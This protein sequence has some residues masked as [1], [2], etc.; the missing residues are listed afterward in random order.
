M[1]RPALHAVFLCLM[2]PACS[3]TEMQG[4]DPREYYSRHP[5]KN[6]VE[7]KTEAHL[8]TFEPGAVKLTKGEIENFRHKVN[9]RSM[10]A[11]DSVM[12]DMSKAMLNN[13]SR[14]QSL[15]RMMKY[16]GYN[17]GNVRFQA[18]EGL[19][20]QQAVIHIT[21]AEAVLPDCPD[22]R[23]ASN[24]NYSNTS[25]ANFGCANE[26]NLGL[27]VADPRDLQRGTGELPPAVSERGD[28]VLHDY[29]GGKSYNGQEGS[30]SSKSSTAA[31]GATDTT[32][33][34]PVSAQ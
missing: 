3:S 21:F 19:E 2:L 8:V 7:M 20:R 29:R 11:V 18:G 22:W 23:K 25:Q 27:M 34:E 9:Q 31:G 12:I 33:I 15:E 14:R 24:H 13:S 28:R 6:R 17:G 16:M 1:R 32:S 26:T 5:I 10:M 30:D 4:V